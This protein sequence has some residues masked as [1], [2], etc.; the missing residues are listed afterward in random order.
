MCMTTILL[1][2]S[3]IFNVILCCLY[4]LEKENCEFWK[5]ANTDKNEIIMSIYGCLN[6]KGYTLDKIKAYPYKFKI[7]KLKRKQS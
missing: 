5:K 2:L 7:T 1:I 4:Y 6:K 3:I